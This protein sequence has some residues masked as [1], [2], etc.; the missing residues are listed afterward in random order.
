MCILILR[1][2]VAKMLS[3]ASSSHACRERVGGIVT[4][5]DHEFEEIVEEYEE[6][7]LV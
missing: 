5:G 6:K 4:T 3:V 1:V 2:A 7:I